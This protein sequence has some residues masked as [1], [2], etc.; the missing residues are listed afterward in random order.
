LVKFELNG[1]ILSLNTTKCFNPNLT[2]QLLLRAVI[3]LTEGFGKNFKSVLELGCGAGAI[4]IYLAKYGYFKNVSHLSLSDISQEA[5]SI[6]QKN[7]IKNV[8]SQYHIKPKFK[9]GKGLD[10]WTGNTF[11]LIIDD[12]SAVSDEVARLSDWFDFAPCE[13]G[14]DGMKNTINIIDSGKD[15][16]KTGGTLVFPVLSLSNV[17][18][19]DEYLSA[20][21]Y[22]ITT[23]QKQKWPLPFSMIEKYK[24][25]L[26]ELRNNGYIHFDEKFGQFIAETS[27]YALKL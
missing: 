3:E 20:A 21:G 2:T 10:P 1:K 11:D 25:R 6:A 16:L 23:L 17:K 7:F 24:S 27:C 15:F 18:M 26:L 19:L 12:I 14:I 22:K 9:S 13:A 5:V 4:S 8:G